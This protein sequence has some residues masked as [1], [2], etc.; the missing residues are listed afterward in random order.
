MGLSFGPAADQPRLTPAELRRQQ[1]AE[2]LL[3]RQQEDIGPYLCET[4]RE[5]AARPPL[6]KV[7]LEDTVVYTEEEMQTS[8]ALAA[9]EAEWRAKRLALEKQA[10]QLQWQELFPDATTSD[11]SSVSAYSSA[12]GAPDQGKRPKRFPSAPKLPSVNVPRPKLPFGQGRSA[13][14]SA[15]TPPAAPPAPPPAAPPAPAPAPAPTRE[16]YNP[17]LPEHLDRSNV[18][19]L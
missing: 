13:G 9:E 12:S 14:Q 8:A 11:V 7:V 4:E 19:D 10:L 6:S 5:T 17:V 2:A 15:T 3:Q 18:R 16:P 1:E